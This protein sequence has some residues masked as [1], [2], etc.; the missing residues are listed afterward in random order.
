MFGLSK[1]ERYK[2]EVEIALTAMLCDFGDDEYFENIK[3]RCV[4]H[5]IP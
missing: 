1:R 4:K 2:K 5:A 3:E